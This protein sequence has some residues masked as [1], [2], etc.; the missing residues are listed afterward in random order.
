VRHNNPA[1]IALWE[2]RVIWPLVDEPDILVS[3][4]TGYTAAAR[5][6]EETITGG[7]IPRL[8][9]PLMHSMDGELIW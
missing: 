5:G 6:S 9:Q 2:S 4:G 3:I 7:F 1:K 8:L